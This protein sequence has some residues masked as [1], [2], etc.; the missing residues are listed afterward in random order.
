MSE[1]IEF[2]SRN[3]D[4]TVVAD[5]NTEYEQ[6]LLEGVTTTIGR[7]GMGVQGKPQRNVTSQEVSSWEGDPVVVK[8]YTAGRDLKK[9][10][11]TIREVDDAPESRYRWY[12]AI[13]FHNPIQLSSLNVIPQR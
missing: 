11:G 1:S 4:V 9:V 2:S 10:K 5:K 8:L 3:F 13:E 12:L 6:V 7:I